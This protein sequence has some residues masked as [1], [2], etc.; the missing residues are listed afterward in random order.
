MR[1]RKQLLVV[2]VVG[3]G[4]G[5]GMSGCPKRA[6]PGLG[7]PAASMLDRSTRLYDSSPYVAAARCCRSEQQRRIRRGCRGSPRWRCGVTQGRRRP[8]ASPQGRRVRI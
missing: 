4:G 8:L 7:P 3:G 1:N 2:V 6:C 5:A